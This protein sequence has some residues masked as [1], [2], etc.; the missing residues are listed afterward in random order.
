MPED[1]YEIL[2]VPKNASQDE[3]KKA[4]REL[5]LKFHPDRNKSKAAEEKFKKVNEA[6]AVLGDE[7]KRKQYDAYGPEGFNQRFT[8]E[9]I[10][11]NFDIEDVLRSMG[12]DFGFGSFGD[13]NIFSNMFG[14]NQRRRDGD[15]GSDILAKVDV[16]LL[17]ASKGTEKDIYV[18]HVVKCESCGGSGA[19]PGSKIVIC[20]KCRGSGQV[21][22]TMR[23]PFGIMQS[24]STCPECRGM[25]K[26]P[27]AV[28]KACG[29]TGKM[30]TENK[31]KVTIPKGVDTG[32]HLRVR[33]MGDYGKDRQ[34]DLYVDVNVLKDKIFRRE[35]SNLYA[36]LH[37]PFY[38][39]A[40]GGRV[41]APTLE[42]EKE[43][44]IEEGAQNGSSITLRGMGMP[45]FNSSGRGDEIL[46][47]VVDIPK[48]LTAEQ[49][50]LLG[51]FASLDL[52]RKKRF[53]IF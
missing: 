16:S 47:I 36:E 9:D 6:Y 51:K 12:I 2:G 10:F 28:C 23:S 46:K 24:I 3:I 43:V 25:G 32:T 53:G 18:R 40:L 50:D 34:G 11:R 7:Q 17:D 37:V 44:V 13:S 48:H 21:A 20:E 15:I 30:Q 41:Y 22:T 33:G 5:A 14:F 52:G 42:G 45:H 38:I 26:M 29:G 19:R 35:G 8:Q 31:I 4:Y 1:Y 39:A 49:R 27:S